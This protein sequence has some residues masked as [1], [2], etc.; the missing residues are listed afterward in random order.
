[1]TLDLTAH[2]GALPNA[3][4][5]A[6]STT[7]SD[8]MDHFLR[9]EWDDAQVDA[10]RFCETA[11][12]YLEWK[13]SGSF[14]PIDGKSKPNRKNVVNSAKNDTNLEPSLRAQMPQ[15]IELTMDF[16]NNRN[17]AHLGNI[18]ANKLDATTVVSTVTWM[19]S[20]VVRLET[21]KSPDEVQTLI[22]RLAE[23]H[24]PL[25][26]T[27]NGQPIV[28][29]PSLDASDKAL[30]ILYQQGNVIPLQTLRK[31]VGYTNTTRWRDMVIKGLQQK[32]FVHVDTAGDVTLLLPGEAAAQR[33]ILDAG[34]L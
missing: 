9:E 5:K 34:G 31:W 23:R 24:V 21:Q 4:V 22:D 14:T 7:Y 29:Q 30:V 10:G 2:L 12:R 28:L 18:D 19:V 3:L 33:I 20:E 27:V 11:L 15:S 1:M 6:V 17:S 13:M 32:A 16:R 25:I 8:V 26:Q